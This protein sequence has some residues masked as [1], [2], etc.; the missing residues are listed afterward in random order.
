MK[1]DTLNV[2]T[3]YNIIYRMFLPLTLAFVDANVRLVSPKFHAAFDADKW[4]L[5]PE[6]RIID[7]YYN[8]RDAGKFPTI[9]V[10]NFF[11]YSAYVW[12][13]S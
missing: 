9:D 8:A 12:L 13:T 4:L 3:R 1:K 6:T 7:V 5:L 11:D 10:C 2:D